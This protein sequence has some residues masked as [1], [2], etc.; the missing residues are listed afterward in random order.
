[1]PKFTQAAFPL[2]DEDRKL[3]SSDLVRSRVSEALAK[4]QATTTKQ[5]MRIARST[6]PATEDWQS[7][8][9]ALRSAGEQLAGC[10]MRP[11]G[12]VD[13]D[14]LIDA[15]GIRVQPVKS[16]GFEAMIT[17]GPGAFVIK[18]QQTLSNARRRASLAHELGHYFFWDRR[19]DPPQRI[20]EYPL[21]DSLCGE[22]EEKCCWQ[23]ARR[24]LVPTS[25]LM[26]T[27]VD[28]DSMTATALLAVAGNL[29][30]SPSLLAIRLL[31]NECGMENHA[32]LLQEFLADSGPRVRLLLGQNLRQREYA[33]WCH[34]LKKVNLK[35]LAQEGQGQ[36]VIE[37][38]RAHRKES[39]LFAEDITH[40]ECSFA[41]HS[42]RTYVSWIKRQE[43]SE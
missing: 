27:A 41:W 7:L 23:F 42:G 22:M 9:D 4:A 28:G 8:G 12:Y 15:I 38:G 14:C 16:I 29:G 33:D 36:L 25:S 24:T 20:L 21:D 3:R 19:V 39:V 34:E 11:S 32:C 31:E 43:Y 30:V 5:M 17:P 40:S 10:V 2:I 18:I 1:M 6:N 13:I 35:Q 37:N 26:A